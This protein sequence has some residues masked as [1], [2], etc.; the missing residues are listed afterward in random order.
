[1]IGTTLVVAAKAAKALTRGGRAVSKKARNC[2]SNSVSLDLSKG[3][4]VEYGA[5]FALALSGDSSNA[6]ELAS[7]LEKR[8]EESVPPI[9][10]RATAFHLSSYRSRAGLHGPPVLHVDDATNCPVALHGPMRHIPRFPELGPFQSWR[11]SPSHPWRAAPRS[12]GRCRNPMRLRGRLAQPFRGR[13]KSN[14]LSRSGP[15][16]RFVSEP[17]QRR[18]TRRL[19]L[20]GTRKPASRLC[21]PRGE[22]NPPPTYSTFVPYCWSAF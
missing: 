14:K 17:Y 21:P 12:L 3:R 10:P 1:V 7:D 2:A 5:A 8:K 18:S 20:R 6:Q 15:F 22:T 11:R 16:P 19:A 9:R 13:R 4:D